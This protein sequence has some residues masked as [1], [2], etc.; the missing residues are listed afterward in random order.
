MLAGR[1][2]EAISLG[3]RTLAMA[4]RL[5]LAD[6]RANALNNI[7]VART[8]QGDP[9]GLADLEASIALAEEANS[10]WDV[11]RGY[12]NLASV[13]FQ[14]GRP[15]RAAELHDRGLAVAERYGL[16]EGVRWLHAEQAFDRYHSGRWDEGLALAEAFI[17]EVDAGQ[18]HYMEMQCRSIRAAIRMARGDPKGAVGDSERTLSLARTAK[19]PQALYPAFGEHAR[20]L[21]LAGREEEARATARELVSMFRATGP[22]LMWS[23]GF[24]PL[25]HVLGS[26]PDAD[27]LGLAAEAVAT[28][29]I[30]A[31][32]AIAVGDLPGAADT[33]AAIGA[34]TEEAFA[35]LMA[36]ERLSADGRRDEAEAHLDKAIA[37]Y[38]SV[39]ATAYVDRAEALLRSTA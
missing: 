2:D 30:D 9:G 10:P 14:M 11:S 31:G 24:I 25:A 32:R 12:L 4:E 1:N 38:R 28:P 33:L 29:W 22:D 5:G 26:D 17:D 8:S 39:N 13:T 15:Q 18:V 21:F 19:D 36:G 16:A 23:A 35:R 27:L 6:L 7:G 34:R 20:V 37:F 3:R